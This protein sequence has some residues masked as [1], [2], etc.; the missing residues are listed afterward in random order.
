MSR[1]RKA[2]ALSLIVVGFCFYLSGC[3]TTYRTEVPVSISLPIKDPALLTLAKITDTVTIDASGT[4]SAGQY[5]IGKHKLSI[6]DKTEFHITFKLPVGGSST[7]LVEQ[8]DG[9]FKTSAP[10]TLDGIPG[11]K[12]IELHKGVASAEVDIGRVIVGFLLNA[13]HTGEEKSFIPAGIVENVRISSAQFSILD[14]SS[15]RMAASYALFGKGSSITLK[16]VEVSF[17]GG[18]SNWSGLLIANLNLKPLDWKQDKLKMR[19]NTMQI[20][21]TLEAKRTTDQIDL[22]LSKSAVTKIDLNSIHLRCGKPNVLAT[23]GTVELSKFNASWPNNLPEPIMM[24]E[25]QVKLKS[26]RLNM[27]FADGSLSAVLGTDT[28][29]AIKAN[30][31]E[32]ER[33]LSATLPNP[34]SESAQFSYSSKESTLDLIIN[35]IKLGTFQFQDTGTVNASMDGGQF[36]LSSLRWN[37][38]KSNFHLTTT[39]SKVTLKSWTAST[40]ESLTKAVSSEIPISITAGTATMERGR[41]KLL[42]KNLSGNINV[43]VQK[44]GVRIR[45]AL[46]SSN[47]GEF[48]GLTIPGVQTSLK[49]IKLVT[50]GNHLRLDLQDL[51]VTIPARVLEESIKK[52]VPKHEKFT[53]NKPI[54]EKQKW[55]YRKFIVKDVE[56]IAPKVKAFNV[57]GASALTFEGSSDIKVTGTVERLHMSLSGKERGWKEHPWSASG[58]ISGKGDAVYK[59]N[60]GKSLA[61]STIDYEARLRLPVPE[62]LNVDWSKVSND[63]LGKSEHALIGSAIKHANHFTDKDGIPIQF[64]GS[65]QVFSNP[66]YILRSIQVNRIRI[67]PRDGVVQI[68]IAGGLVM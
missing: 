20:N 1:S 7:L 18:R 23:S 14:G 31:S 60:V 35:Q 43:A 61:E 10:L 40:K 44:N 66:I 58:S 2:A 19:V 24:V 49:N 55:R 9:V 22:S 65:H 33:S 52:S 21:T 51:N 57:T 27:P 37:A 11:P 25:S 39:G 6:P 41:S 42:F 8:A 50:S 13:L 38:N 3:S 56:A 17:K 12:R 54:L 36:E 64:K 15:V 48:G 5:K 62:K 28:C 68:Q 47:T 34:K 63:L 67:F 30:R 45:G 59:L 29:L 32:T 16:D 53:L 4:L 46:S 26:A